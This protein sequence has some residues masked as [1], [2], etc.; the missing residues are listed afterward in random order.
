MR[1]YIKCMY[2][3]QGLISVEEYFAAELSIDSQRA[4]SEEELLKLV[5]KLEK[6][7][8]YKLKVKKSATTEQNKKN[9][10]VKKYETV[11]SSI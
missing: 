2:G 5:A 1:I 6:L 8:K 11:W 3:G 7:E 9:G 4:N 10:P